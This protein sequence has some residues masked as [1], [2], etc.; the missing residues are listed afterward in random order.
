MGVVV[1]RELYWVLKEGHEEEGQ[2]KEHAVL[3]KTC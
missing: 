1:L 2:L 3:I